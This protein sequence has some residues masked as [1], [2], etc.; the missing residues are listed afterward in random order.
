MSATAAVLAGRAAVESLMLDTCKVER[1]TET[2][3]DESG[4]LEQTATLL[5]E[6][7]CRVQ[8]PEAANREALAGGY[9]YTIDT[10][11]L[12][13]P[14]TGDGYEVDPDT[15][16]Q[17]VIGKD[18]RVTITA[19]GPTTDPDLLDA[20]RSVQGQGKRKSHPVYRSLICEAVS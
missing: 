13:L 17:Y 2:F 20:T 6:G 16:R 10:T 9:S 8:D 11:V 19:L 5:Y 18:D 15:G 4:E 7:P 3:D 14:V 12:Q 1:I